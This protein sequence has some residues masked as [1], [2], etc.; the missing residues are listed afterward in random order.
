MP[1]DVATAVFQI[2]YANMPHVHQYEPV[3]SIDRFGMLRSRRIVYAD[4]KRV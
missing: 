3:V 4:A 2:R 1:F